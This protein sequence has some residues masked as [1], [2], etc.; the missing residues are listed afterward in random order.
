MKIPEGLLKDSSIER[1][2][3]GF[4]RSIGRGIDHAPPWSFCID[5]IG[6]YYDATRPS[7]LEYLCNNLDHHGF[8][9]MEK[10]AAAAMSLLLSTGITKYNGIAASN[11]AHP[12]IYR[13][14]A[15]LVLGQVEDDASITR[16]KNAI[17]TNKSLLERAVSDNPSSMIYFKQH[18]DCLGARR[19]AGY[20]NCPQSERIIE[21]DPDVSLPEALT[22]VDIVYTISSLGGFEALLRGKR[23]V[24]FGNPFYAGWG[25]TTDHVAFPRRKVSLSILEL[26]YVAYMQYPAYLNPH[27]G[28]RLALINVIQELSSINA[29]TIPNDS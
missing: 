24:T 22:S 16:N 7:A 5:P 15:V 20:I 8:K 3:D 9:L 12:P 17:S 26:F 28:Q 10:H 29:T 4:V 18:P 27:T 14:D 25:L 11:P 1:I 23:V 6:M 19:R 2:E 13:P 21:V